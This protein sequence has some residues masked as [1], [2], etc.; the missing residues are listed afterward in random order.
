MGH[1]LRVAVPRKSLM[2]DGAHSSS[3][4]YNPRENAVAIKHEGKL[5]GMARS[6]QDHAMFRILLFLRKSQK[7]G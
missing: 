1:P 2:L 5:E 6:L 3:D 7:G 4:Q